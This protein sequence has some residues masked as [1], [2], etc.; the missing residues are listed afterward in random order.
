MKNLFKTVSISAVFLLSF[1][2]TASALSINPN[3]GTYAPNTLQ[4]IAI[5]ASLP[6]ESEDAN[7]VKIR[8]SITGATFVENTFIEDKTGKLSIPTCEGGV[9][10]TSTEFCMDTV[11]TTGS[12]SNN[13]LL[14]QITIRF[15]SG[16]STAS[17]LVSNGTEY[18]V[19]EDLAPI[20]TGAIASYIISEG[21]QPT[22][23]PVAGISD[24]P[25]LMLA[26]GVFTVF[27]GLGFF[28]IRNKYSTE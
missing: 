24:H 1:T 3:S 20:S 13:E 15:N 11:K 9:F 12:F 19:G 17:I 16:S 6:A 4:N 23:L 5:L 28:A 7:G 27:L 8:L 25:A 26:I 14:G 2:S 22:T 21:V 10:Y 18:L